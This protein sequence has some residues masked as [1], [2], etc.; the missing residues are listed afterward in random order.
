M[1][2]AILSRLEECARV[3]D[4]G[5]FNIYRPM[6]GAEMTDTETMAAENV[7]MRAALNSALGW[8]KHWQADAA[9]NLAPTQSSMEIAEREIADVLKAVSNA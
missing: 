2:A 7:R 5:R 9:C 1:T 4:L 3:G 8:V 6:I